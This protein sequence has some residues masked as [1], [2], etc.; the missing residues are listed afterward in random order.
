[1]KFRLNVFK[2][3]EFQKVYNLFPKSKSSLF[4]CYKLRY[5]LN[6]KLTI[7][8]PTKDCMDGISITHSSMEKKSL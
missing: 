4:T 3:K 5:S 7:I 8:V 6:C 2:M 1:M